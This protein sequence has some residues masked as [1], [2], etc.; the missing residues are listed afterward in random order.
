M[1]IQEIQE[2]IDELLNKSDSTQGTEK[3]TLMLEAWKLI[4][5]DRQFTEEWLNSTH[6]IAVSLIDY[7]SKINQSENTKKWLKIEKQINS[8]SGV[9][10]KNECFL[11][12]VYFDIGDLDQ[13]FHY[14]DITYEEQG[15]TPFR[16]HD[17]KYWQFY[18]ETKEKTTPK[19][20]RSKKNE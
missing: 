7:Y 12:R 14:F 5:R 10:V 19:K 18:K 4:P 1:N 6:S 15:Y 2:K 17:K 9:T 20:P 13:A 11:G 16:Y 8:S 3:E